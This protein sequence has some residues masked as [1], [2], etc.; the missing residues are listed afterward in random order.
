MRPL[1]EPLG[2]ALPLASLQ[3]QHKKTGPPEEGPVPIRQKV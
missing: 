1:E 3:A 2:R